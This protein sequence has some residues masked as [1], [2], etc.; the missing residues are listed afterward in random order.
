M[1]IN[2]FDC[3]GVVINP[4]ETD[5]PLVVDSNAVLALAVSP[6]R[7]QA[8]TRNGG[9]V[10]QASRRID[11]IEFPLRYRSDSLKGT[12]E[13]TAK[14]FSVSLSPKDRMTG[15]SYYRSNS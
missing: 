11:V 10:R 7:L 12:A 4:D 9:Q 15:L 14:T 8:I 2:D 13:A 6:K 1:V 3:G 5:P